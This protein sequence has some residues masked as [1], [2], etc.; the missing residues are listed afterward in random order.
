M[1]TKKNA[2]ADSKGTER[3]VSE[4]AAFEKAKKE[5]QTA[6]ELLYR[7]DFAA[8]K[9]LLT[10]IEAEHAD[11]AE[12]V[13]RCRTYVK[14]CNVRLAGDPPAPQSV[15]DC[16]YRA[17]ML[18]NDGRPEEAVALLDQALV[19]DPTSVRVLYARACAWAL[20]ANAERAVSDLRSAIA[21]D[22][23][24]RFQATNDQDFE[25]IRE[26]P[27]FIDVIEPTPAGA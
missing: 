26:E 19:Q 22:P 15:D 4:T 6:I 23:T 24:V 8:A 13:E 18:A 27:S 7:H 20:Q 9:E 16:Y 21:V 10:K 5:Y 3:S 14:I 2:A 25:K 17:I 12:M 11:E 1:A